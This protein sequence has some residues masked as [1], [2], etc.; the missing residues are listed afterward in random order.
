MAN[1][2]L[3]RVIIM[4]T[5]FEWDFRPEGNINDF[6]KRNINAYDEECDTEYIETNLTGIVKNVAKID[7]I[8]SKAA[9]EWPIEQIASIDCAILRLSIYELLFGR[10]IPPKVVINEAVELGKTYGSENS[11]KFINGVLGTLFKNDAR[12]EEENK[13]I[14]LLDLSNNKENKQA[15]KKKKNE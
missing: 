9:P 10:E 12:F 6:V 1:R 14:T 5:L 11:F 2:H 15:K 4:Q 3:S 7:E 13:N 8:I